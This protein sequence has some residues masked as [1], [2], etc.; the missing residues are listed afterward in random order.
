MKIS[1]LIAEL[2]GYQ[3]RY[4][5]LEVIIEQ[6]EPF[7]GVSTVENLCLRQNWNKKDEN[8]IFLDW[9]TL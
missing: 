1:E 2:E 9:R 5:N 3:A 6:E 7:Y 8:A 4:G